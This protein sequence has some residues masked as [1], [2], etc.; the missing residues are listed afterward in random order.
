MTRLQ[1]RPIPHAINGLV[2]LMERLPDETL[3]VHDVMRIMIRH[4]FDQNFND[5]EALLALQDMLQPELRNADGLSK[6]AMEFSRLL[7]VLQETYHYQL[8]VRRASQMATLYVPLGSDYAVLTS[9]IEVLVAIDTLRSM[10]QTIM[11]NELVYRIAVPAGFNQLA[12]AG[13]KGADTLLQD[14][15][16]AKLSG[17]RIPTASELEYT[18]KEA[19]V[20]DEAVNEIH[21]ILTHNYFNLVKPGWYDYRVEYPSDWEVI[22]IYTRKHAKLELIKG[23]IDPDEKEPA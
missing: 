1:I 12:A 19:Q 18:D 15:I 5:R 7:A 8:R 20:Y 21:L 23:D 2:Y 14:V 17:E 22:V 3:P 13:A 11:E 10:G 9:P 6:L 16:N 4:L